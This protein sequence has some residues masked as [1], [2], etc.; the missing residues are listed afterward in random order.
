MAKVREPD[1]SRAGA[2]TRSTAWLEA[3]AEYGALFHG[4]P[5]PL[6]IERGRGCELWDVDG[7]RY[8]DFESS[9]YCMQTGHSHPKVVLAAREQAQTLMQI[10][11]RFT[12]VPRIKLAQKLASIAPFPHARTFFLTTGSEANEA[13]FRLAKRSTGSFEVVAL[14]RGFHGRT[15]AS[16]SASIFGL[17]ERAGYGPVM[18]G[19]CAIPAPYP[20]RCHFQCGSCDLRCWEL[21]KELIERTTSG[22]PAALIMEFVLGGGGVI[23]IPRNFAQAVRSFCSERGALIIADEALTGMGRTGRWFA[24][25]HTGVVPDIIVTSKALGGG[26]PL[27]A[28][29][30]S[31]EI[32]DR[33]MA[34]GFVQAATHEGDPL[35]CAIGLANFEVMKQENLVDRAVR[36]GQ[37][38]GHGLREIAERHESIGDVRGLGLLWGIE[39]VRDRESK[40]ED[41]ELTAT[42]TTECLRRGLIVGGPPPGSKVNVIRLAPP[43]IVKPEEIDEALEILGDAVE[44][45]TKASQQTPP[46]TR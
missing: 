28:L 8:L 5:S 41:F 14:L 36:M 1:T 7:S 26:V 35:Q 34:A 44:T 17:N 30:T 19:V 16:F 2:L 46:R 3:A 39:F 23:P 38:F 40:A 20:Y 15:L 12:N 22:R 43:L 31:L 4:V 33:A 11:S 29:M 25:E 32:V 27:S 6:V 45:A 10:G 42:V 18:P 24:S 37:R 9:Q 21:G 13:A